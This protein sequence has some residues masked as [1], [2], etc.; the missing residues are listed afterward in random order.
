MSC[1]GHELLLI[2]YLRILVVVSLVGHGRAGL[3]RGYDLDVY[4]R[5]ILGELEIDLV[6]VDINGLDSQLIAFL[7]LEGC[8][9]GDSFL[10]IVIN[11]DPLNPEDIYQRHQPL[12]EDHPSAQ[13]S[14]E[15]LPFWLCCSLGFPPQPGFQSRPDS[16]QNPPT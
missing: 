5:A 8:A 11:K 6:A 13:S 4:Y 2:A 15:K 1:D 14:A 3:G 9:R 10:G 16:G 12:L 7:K